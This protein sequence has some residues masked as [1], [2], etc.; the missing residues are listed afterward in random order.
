MK[1]N[2]VDDKFSRARAHADR[3]GA[4]YVYA[5]LTCWSVEATAAPVEACPKCRAANVHNEMLDI[6]SRTDPTG[7]TKRGLAWKPMPRRAGVTEPL[8][9]RAVGAAPRRTPKPVQLVPLPMF[10]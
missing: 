10:N 4:R 2:P 3:I 9:Q 1:R 8:C 5:C 6:V 7:E